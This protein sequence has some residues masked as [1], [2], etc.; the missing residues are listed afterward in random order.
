MGKFTEYFFLQVLSDLRFSKRKEDI[1]KNQKVE[2]KE[3]Y[4][5]ENQK[6]QKENWIKE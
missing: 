6:G 4:F 2:E 1:E 5:E 3:N